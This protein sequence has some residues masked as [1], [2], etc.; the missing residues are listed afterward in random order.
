MSLIVD[1]KKRLGSFSLSAQ[2][3]AGEGVTGILGSSGCGKSMTL[4]CIAGIERPDSGHIELD[5]V[6]LYD[7]R[8]R[9]DLHPQ[10][11]RVGYLFQNYALFPNMTLRQNILCG[12]RNQLDKAQREKEADEMIALMGL[13]GLEKHRPYQL[14]GG[15]QQRVAIARALVNRPRVLLLD[16]PLGALDLKLR[17]GMQIE[18]KRMQQKLGITF[19]YVTH[20]QEEALTM[21]DTIVV[22]NEGVIQQIGTPADIYNEPKNVFVA[23]FIGE[24]NI[25]PGVMLEDYKVRFHDI[26]FECVDAGFGC[27]TPVDVVVRP[28]DID[29]MPLGKTA[30][31][32]TIKSVLFMGVHYEFR[33]ETGSF[34]WTVHSTD[35]VAPDTEISLEI[36][37]DAIHIMHKSLKHDEQ[38]LLTEDEIADAAAAAE[39]E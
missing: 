37:P 7:S 29:I 24:S 10:Q 23:K 32:G 34:T 9:I 5:G 16:E 11:R 27:N 8:K 1:I 39:E 31:K 12:L 18:L 17:K 25:I 36:V 2:L 35:Y 19:I 14:S 26:D 38:E 30:L 15:Q 21:S 22:M 28:E 3:E 13:N 4:K 20:D 6:V 33:I